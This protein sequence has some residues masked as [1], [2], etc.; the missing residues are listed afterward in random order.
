[1]TMRDW[2]LDRFGIEVEYAHTHG[3]SLVGTVGKI[4]AAG[5]IIRQQTARTRV[6]EPV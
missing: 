6:P 3:E 4:T 1:M 5:R 2:S